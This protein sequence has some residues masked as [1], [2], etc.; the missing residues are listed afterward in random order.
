M[1]PETRALLLRRSKA[2][3]MTRMV[4]WQRVKTLPGSKSEV[5]LRTY[6]IS[7]EFPA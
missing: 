3:E 4:A 1:H 2:M 7:T 5:L 6:R